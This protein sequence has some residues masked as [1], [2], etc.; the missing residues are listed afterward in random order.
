MPKAAVPRERDD[1]EVI[2]P[3]GRVFALKARRVR[4]PAR[5]AYGS[6]RGPRPT[7]ETNFRFQ[8]KEKGAPFRCPFPQQPNKFVSISGLNLAAADHEENN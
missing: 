5:R 3:G 7:T 8:T 1:T 4:P 6:E 2:P